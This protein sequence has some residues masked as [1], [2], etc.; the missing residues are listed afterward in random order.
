M[1]NA[2]NLI[3]VLGPTASG[4]TAFAA[5]LAAHLD[6]EIISADSRQV[7]R[8]MDLGTGKDYADYVVDGKTVPAHLID[9][10]EAGTKYNVYR[11]QQDF[12]RVFA[13]LREAGKIP[14]VCGGTGMYI[15]AV[16]KGYK[17]L[18]VPVN[19]TL[20]EELNQKTTAE[21]VLLF[22]SLATPH[23]VSDTSQRKRLI[24]AIEIATYYKQYEAD[25]VDFPAIHP[26]FIGVRFD[27]QSQRRRITQRL[28]QRLNDGMLSEVQRLLD[29]G[30]P[31]ED[32]I[33]Y[34]LEYK[35]MT[36]HLT[37]QLSYNTM[38]QKLNTAIH[39]FAKR[40]MTWFRKMER[41][42]TKIHWLDGYMPPE[43]KMQHALRWINN[44]SSKH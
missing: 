16:T 9:I 15:E 32:L 39:Q 6:T 24:R 7:Y 43:E 2:L 36:L 40:Q 41:S 20:R 30:I 18:Q 23:N 21:L 35:F 10:M 19:E 34:G 25:N 22:E 38:V 8:Q 44:Y 3:I 13:A 31:P 27:R 4:K 26:L 28:H 37:G 14:V 29:S 11:Y 17:L 12:L 5:Q 42:G 1:T 33:F